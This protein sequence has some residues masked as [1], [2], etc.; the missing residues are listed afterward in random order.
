[1]LARS[2]SSRFQ[3][4]SPGHRA[5]YEYRLAETRKRR[6]Q[7]LFLQDGRQN[8]LLS[9]D[10]LSN[11]LFIEREQD[12][13]HW[14]GE[15]LIAIPQND[16]WNKSPCRDGDDGKNHKPGGRQVARKVSHNSIDCTCSQTSTHMYVI[17][18]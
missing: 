15:Q 18:E 8:R 4:R 14:V 17:A 1:M 6:P 3:T 13:N 16:S 7:S 12:T 9:T 2:R 10:V 11:P 5:K